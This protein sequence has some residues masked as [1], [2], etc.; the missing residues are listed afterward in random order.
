MDACHLILGR[1]WKFDVKENHNGEINI[2]LIEKNVRQ[3]K[4][5]P[6]PDHMVKDQDDSVVMIIR[7]KEFLQLN[8][9]DEFQG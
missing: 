9:E 2:Y 5:E 4:M 6:F 1:P 8:R 3:L 7:G